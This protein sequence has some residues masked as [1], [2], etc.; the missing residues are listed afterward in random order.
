MPDRQPVRR[1]GCLPGTVRTSP[2]LRT[3]AEPSAR[4]ASGS[5]QPR[6]RGCIP[7]VLAAVIVS[8]TAPVG[9]ARAQGTIDPGSD[10]WSVVSSGRQTFYDFAQTPIPADFIDD[11][12]EAFD[13]RVDFRGVTL[14]SIELP[15]T[16]HLI[17]QR[18]QP[19]ELTGPGDEVT[20]NAELLVSSLSSTTPVTIRVNGQDT[21]WRVLLGV[22]CTPRAIGTMTIRQES[23]SGGTLDI[24]LPFT[25]KFSFINTEDDTTVIY[26]GGSEGITVVLSAKGIPWAFDA[27][28]CDAAMLEQTLILPAICP[29]TFVVPSN[30]NFFAGRTGESDRCACAF[31]LLDAEEGD[32]AIEPAPAVQP[33][34]GDGDGISDDCDNCPIT[35]NITQADTDG[36]G[37][38]D[39]CDNCPE[40]ANPDQTDADGDG[41]GDACDNCLDVANP[42]QTDADGDG[43]GDLCDNCPAHPDADQS[44]GD[45]DG[46]GD[47]CDNCPEDPNPDQADS[48]GDGI[49]DVCASDT[50]A[51]GI[52][53]AL[54]NCPLDPNLDQADEDGDSVGDACDGCPEDP[55]KSEPGDCGCGVPETD[56][57]GDGVA[58]CVDNC[59]EAANL[60]QRDDD[61]DG[62]GN[63]CDNCPTVPNGT[64]T[65]SDDDGTG[66]V[67]DGCPLD[68]L[69]ADPGDC[70]CGQ[71][72]DD[73]DEDGVGNCLDN[74]PEDPN[75][76][77]A[78][79]DG[80]GVGDACDGCPDDPLKSAP[81]SC[82]C[83]APDDDEDDD[84]VFGC[85]DIC[86][87]VFDPGQTDADQDGVGDFCDNCPADFNPDQADRDGD[88]VGDACDLNDSTGSGG[89]RN[90]CGLGLIGVLPMLSCA[91]VGAR[92]FRRRCG[93][94]GT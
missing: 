81:G 59:P 45:G 50:D 68:P 35:P 87:D 73:A 36:D 7:T 49:G 26:D 15:E 55:E 60:D 44:D 64:Q 19:V 17:I 77:Q 27:E 70:G 22:S 20:T 33:E 84:G 75:P 54:D 4:G 25:P 91:L 31:A 74:C 72:E 6:G 51:D 83:G 61:G 67:C 66:D 90:P 5:M 78:D 10:L 29:D 37:L 40:A 43:I 28:P 82:G 69:K 23:T 88:G 92:W 71:A 85:H 8:L 76:D 47:A 86:P 52:D 93:G 1:C 80:D 30:A 62:V 38:G 39:G 14:G 94:S 18:N 46:V 34:D 9:V 63:V 56:T 65:D 48:N 89:P 2:A 53:D 24:E 13:E 79:G 12:A 21:E 16:V 57:D 42:G 41:A 3:T 11:G 32:I 58:D